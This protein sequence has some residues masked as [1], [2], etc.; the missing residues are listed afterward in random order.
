MR[1][2]E[3]IKEKGY[4][5]AQFAEK[6]GISLSALNQQ[7][8]SLWKAY[9]NQYRVVPLQQKTVFQPESYGQGNIV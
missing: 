8:P 7:M 1:I 4:T 9:K 3:I 2:K 5:Q 6:L